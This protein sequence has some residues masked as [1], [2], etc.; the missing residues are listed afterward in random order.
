MIWKRLFVARNRIKPRRKSPGAQ[1]PA[2]TCPRRLELGAV[3]LGVLKGIAPSR[4]EGLRHGARRSQETRRTV[5]P[6]REITLC[7]RKKSTRV[8][9]LKRC[10]YCQGAGKKVL[11]P[12]NGGCSQPA[13]VRLGLLHSAA[14]SG[15]CLTNLVLSRVSDW[16]VF[17]SLLT[18]LPKERFVHAVTGKKS[19]F[20]WP[21]SL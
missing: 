7:R 17:W 19:N 3:E 16:P 6:T 13:P 5:M 11:R 9:L 1:P 15:A 20:L 8:L 21:R 4:R 2:D 14:H 18:A 12:E 10:C